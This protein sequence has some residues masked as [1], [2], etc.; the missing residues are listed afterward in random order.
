MKRLSSLTK[1]KTNEFTAVGADL[2]ASRIM[3]VLKCLDVMLHQITLLLKGRNKGE[4][5]SGEGFNYMGMYGRIYLFFLF[6]HS[7]S[8]ASGDTAVRLAAELPMGLMYFAE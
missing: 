8:A 1:D 7:H 5:L 3:P 4:W 2:G 6:S